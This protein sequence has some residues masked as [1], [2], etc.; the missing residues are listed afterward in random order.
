MYLYLGAPTCS[1]S[2]RLR[3]CVSEAQQA[4]GCK[5]SGWRVSGPGRG[6]T[7]PLKRR[8]ATSLPP[9]QRVLA[10]GAF[11]REGE[12]NQA[13]RRYLVEHLLRLGGYLGAWRFEAD[14][15]LNRTQLGQVAA[16]E[17]L[18]RAGA[19]RS[20]SVCRSLLTFRVF[21]RK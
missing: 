8:L 5:V 13:C 3:S 11:P 20:Q 2:Q 6:H 18:D 15:A 16:N 1:K 4:S 19:N 7:W 9:R 21:L 14:V 10:T 17:Y 12:I